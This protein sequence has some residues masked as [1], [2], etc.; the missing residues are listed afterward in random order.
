MFHTTVKTIKFDIDNPSQC[1]QVE[2]VESYYFVQTIDE[3]GRKRL[4]QS[5]CN[6]AARVFFVICTDL[7]GKSDSFSEFFKLAGSNIGC[8]DNYGI[9]KVY[10]SAITV[11]QPTFIHH[12][13]QYVEYIGMRFFNFIQ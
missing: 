2:L 3:F 7:G 12:L 9:F 4:I 6:H 1:I 11:S 10:S 13:Q 8:H 5:F